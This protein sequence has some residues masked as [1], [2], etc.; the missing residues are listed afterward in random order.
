MDNKKKILI[1]SLI[2]A[3]STFSAKAYSIEKVSPESALYWKKIEG[4]ARSCRISELFT[5]H[6]LPTSF[7]EFRRA[8]DACSKAANLLTKGKGEEAIPYLIYAEKFYIDDSLLYLAEIAYEKYRGV[9]PETL[10]EIKKKCIEKWPTRQR[11]RELRDSYDQMTRTNVAALLK[12]SSQSKLEKFFN[13]LKDTVFPLKH[14]NSKFM[15]GISY[16]DVAIPPEAQE[17]DLSIS[18]EEMPI[19]SLEEKKLL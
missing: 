14:K 1:L 5:E 3:L 17:E 16:E 19:L 7:A 10:S 12:L 18:L 11:F 2:M 15:A 8:E 6:H 9:S 13:N 4:E